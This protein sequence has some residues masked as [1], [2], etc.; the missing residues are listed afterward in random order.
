MRDVTIPVVEIARLVFVEIF[1][2]V[3]A[4]ANATA[5][6]SCCDINEW[7]VWNS[8]WWMIGFSIVAGG[9]VDHPSHS[10]F[11]IPHSALLTPSLTEALT[12]DPVRFSMIVVCLAFFKL[13]ILARQYFGNRKAKVS[14]GL[15]VLVIVCIGNLL[16]TFYLVVDPAASRKIIPL[17]WVYILWSGS[18]PFTVIAS[19]TITFYW[20]EL[21]TRTKLV[22]VS[23]FMNRLLWPFIGASAF[24]LILEL[25]SSYVVS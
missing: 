4:G 14:V 12:N 15:V 16:R 11:C 21:I 24:V 18:F 13:A 22:V 23:S 1:R 3:S 6:L 10:A 9:Y 5:S 7:E 17:P 20:L 8:S 2:N 19:L 25:T